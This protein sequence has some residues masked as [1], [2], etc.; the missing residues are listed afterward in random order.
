MKTKKTHHK[1]LKHKVLKHKV[2]KHNISKT[3]KTHNINYPRAAILPHAGEKYAGD[4]RKNILIHFPRYKIKYI[5]YISAIHDSK[6]ILPGVY[7]L[8]KDTTF[9]KTPQLPIINKNEHSFD[10]VENELR[11]HFPNVKIF[12]LTPVKKYDTQIVKWITTFISNNSNSVLFS[13]TDLTHHG[14][15]FNNN[16][17]KFPQRLHKQYLEEH[18]IYSLIQRPLQM[19][20]IKQYTSQ[21]E[22]LCGPYAIQLFCESIKRINYSGKVVDYYDSHLEN[23]KLDKYT[24][25]ST[26]IKNIVSYVSI[27]YGPKINSGKINNFDIMLALGSIKSEIIKKIN[28]ASYRVKL[29]IWSPFYNMHQGVF[30]GTNLN[31]KTNCSYGRYE[32]TNTHKTATKIIEAA[33]DCL[34]DAK[35]RWK[36]PYSNHLLDKLDYKI[37][38]LDPKHKWKKYSGKHTERYF[39][40]NGKQGIYLKLLSGKSA[41]YLPVV[42]REHKHWTID[43]YMENLSEKAGGN[44]YDW[45]KGT[46]WI[47]ESKSYTWDGKK[48]KIKLS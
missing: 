13:T 41:T 20:K 27:I 40:L 17:L 48:H 30:V 35:N 16:I 31:G 15:Q 25:T 32:T 37:E 22:L 24:V 12:V 3:K 18:L 11:T 6:D 34:L 5:I 26:H 8:Y 43:K 42:A 4:A 14:K 9:G 7:Q 28:K 38:L 1:V 45:K 44:K 47:Y 2:L 29:P 39:K 36:I 23:N 33:G 10:W 19:H 21:S 46:I